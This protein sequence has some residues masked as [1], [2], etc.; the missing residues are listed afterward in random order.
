MGRPNK[1]GA[2]VMTTSPKLEGWAKVPVPPAVA[3]SSSP[4][5]CA[6]SR[7]SVHSAPGDVLRHRPD[8]TSY[9][10]RVSDPA[11]ISAPKRRPSLPPLDKTTLTS[12][13]NSTS[14]T[15]EL[16]PAGSANLFFSGRGSRK[17]EGSMAEVVPHAPRTRRDP[18]PHLA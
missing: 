9:S 4:H 11:E 16:N 14:A 18:S 1:S 12:Q 17:A 5:P 6:P 3:K 10:R 15:F 8:I 13:S 7:N 2:R